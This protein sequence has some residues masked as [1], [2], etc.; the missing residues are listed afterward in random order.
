M[1]MALRFGVSSLAVG[2]TVVAFGTSSPELV[3]SLDAET[4][5]ADG[6]VIGSVVGSNLCNL[7]LIL[8][9]A[10]LL[11]PIGVRQKLL[12]VDLPMLIAASLALLLVLLDGELSRIEGAAFLLCIVGYMLFS[13]RRA[14]HHKS[15]TEDKE[16]APIPGLH[17]FPAWLLIGGGIATLTLGAHVFVGGAVSL[18]RVL[19]VSDSLIG[20]T[21]VAFGTES[22]GDLSRRR[23]GLAGAERPCRGQQYLQYLL[24]PWIRLPCSIP[25]RALVSPGQIWG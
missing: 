23:G 8:G 22:A 16:E 21:V 5:G 6:I 18:A 15:P 25:C 24:H 13:L 11:R 3:V 12:R 19:G 20:L 7:L 1:R 14:R 9:L 2:L 4:R 17:K 10:A